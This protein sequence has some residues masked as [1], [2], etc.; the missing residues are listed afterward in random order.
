MNEGQSRC[1]ACE[2]YP[3]EFDRAIAAVDYSAP[4]SELIARFKFQGDSALAKPLAALIASRL[5]GHPKKRGQPQLI[6]PTPLSS[7][8]LRERG[9]NQCG[10]LAQQ[11]SRRLNT[12]TL[13]F[14]LRRVKDTPRMMTLQADER[15][16]QIRNAFEVST[17][18]RRQLAGRHVAVVDD[19][20]TTGATV[21][22]IT[23]TLKNAGVRSVAVW[24]IARTP[25]P[26]AMGPV[27]IV[28]P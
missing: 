23:Q 10:L 9:Y 16:Q 21:N 22:E 2:D 7:T 27:A 15:R 3:P 5:S 26:R 18:Y 8:R 11:L 4:W 1:L 13:P 28:E 17:E 6:I 19:V 14:A 25:A 20:L 12:P 24:V